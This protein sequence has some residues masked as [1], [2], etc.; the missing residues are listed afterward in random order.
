MNKFSVPIK[1]MHCRSCEMLIEEKLSQIPEVRKMNINHKKGEA[2]VY[3]EE[4]KPNMEE[5]ERAVRDAGYEI[6]NNG[7]VYLLSS[8]KEDY[9]DF[10]IA[11]LFLLGIYLVLKN[12]GLTDLNIVPSTNSYSLPV[13][14]MVGL[15]AGLSTCMALVGGLILGISARHAEMHPE[16]TVAQKFRPHIF[17]NVGR[18]AGYA[19]L[20]GFLGVAGSVLQISGL[21]LGILTIVVGLIMLIMGLKLI[22]LFPV[23]ERINFALPKSVAKIFGAGRHQK[24]YSHRGSFVAGALTFFL[25]CG[26]TQAMQLFAVS[27]GSFTQGAL[28][29]GVFALGTAPGLLGIGGLTSAVK[30]IFAK[31]FFKFAGIVV[32]I[33]ALFNISN[34]Y[35]LTGWQFGEA[36]VSDKG[37]AVE[38]KDPNVKMVDGV[39]IVSM[40]ENSRGYSPNKFTIQKGVP[41]RWEIDAQAPNS[42]AAS[43]MISKLGIRKNLKAGKNIIEFTPTETGRLPFS[44][45]MGMYTGVFNVVDGNSD[46]LES[47]DE[48]SSAIPKS[49]GGGCG[50]GSST[51]TDKP[52]AGGGCGGSSGG[53]GGCGGGTTYIPSADSS[54]QEQAKEIGGIQVITADYSVE[55]DIEPKEFSVKVG[56]PVKF[57]INPE[58]DGYGCMTTIMIP[59]LYDVPEFLQEGKEIV[60]E[61]TPKEKGKYNITC[62][63]GMIRGT[64]SVN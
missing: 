52:V 48:D 2:E 28:V 20:G 38:V 49:F 44:C 4:Q 31:R 60:M 53:C 11:L 64:L 9:K 40:V 63:M 30:G 26:F 17:F 12:L 21:F 32:V 56:K 37:S 29:M 35:N 39:Q 7:P 19:F 18:I 43:I 57:V 46:P 6:G 47:S 16:A 50:G 59:G 61:F 58:T 36:A 25:P 1:G 3:W 13:I 24:E 27:T 34:G 23:L 15:A 55:T 22:G 54:E 45:S 62:S 51:A 8:N 33:M 10:G 42:C 5:V 41:V 14:L